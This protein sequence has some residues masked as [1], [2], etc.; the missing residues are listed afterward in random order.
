[1]LTNTRRKFLAAT[2]LTGIATAFSSFS[3]S[4]N[5]HKQLMV[6]HVFF[7]LKNPNSEADRN[8]LIEGV[9]SLA[10]IETVKKLHVGVP[11]KTEQRDVV[12]S[13]YAVS[14]LMFFDDE[15]GEKIYQ[16]HPIHLKFIEEC[17]SLWSKVVVYDMIE[18]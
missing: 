13:G 4:K 7:W 9:K 5:K 17:S 16:T 11:A 14:E 10:A 18:V 2:I 1:M 12:D 8:K 6:H 15:E 3:F